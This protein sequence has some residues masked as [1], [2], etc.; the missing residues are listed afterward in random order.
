MNKIDVDK[1]Y[2]FNQL[3]P[4]KIIEVMKE[5]YLNDKAEIGK[6]S[7]LFNDVY[8]ETIRRDNERKVGKPGTV[9]PEFLDDCITALDNN[10]DEESLRALIAAA[11]VKWAM[12]LNNIVVH[13]EE[14]DANT[15]GLATSRKAYRETLIGQF[16]AL[17]I[18]CTFDA[19]IRPIIY[20]ESIKE[21]PTTFFLR[22][23]DEQY[24]EFTK[25][26]NDD[27]YAILS[28][29][30]VGQNLS[31]SMAQEGFKRGTAA[32]KKVEDFLKD[33]DSVS[34][35]NIDFDT[36]EITEAINN[37]NKKLHIE[38]FEGGFL[39]RPEKDFA[40]GTINRN[41]NLTH[42]MT[43]FD[44]EKEVIDF[45]IDKGWAESRDQFVI[46]SN[47]IKG[48][49]KGNILESLIRNSKTLDDESKDI[50]NLFV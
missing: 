39:V 46:D 50:F 37:F 47:L 35:R 40:N 16:T 1:E 21:L 19:A 44:S 34:G 7:K 17:S 3:T 26:N 6:S 28:N 36:E 14:R 41:D 45:Y 38:K 30:A 4:E 31:S 15:L 43:G 8:M 48:N 32:Y 9:R 49:R 23:G 29:T 42:K 33:L 2:I 22:G 5:F 25:L 10:R 18:P 20:S 12:K 27:D 11:V 24:Y 13:R